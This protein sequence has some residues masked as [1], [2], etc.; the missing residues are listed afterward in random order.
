MLHDVQV[1]L[2]VLPDATNGEEMVM[3]VQRHTPGT[4]PQSG[5]LWTMDQNAQD[6]R[7]TWAYRHGVQLDFIEPGKPVQNGYIESFNCRFRDEC[8]NQHWFTSLSQARSI[9]AAW[10][11]EYNTQ[12]LHSA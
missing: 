6:R 9:I 11:E 5:S 7:S 1:P 2:A 12:R 10:R 8:L 3:L 4:E